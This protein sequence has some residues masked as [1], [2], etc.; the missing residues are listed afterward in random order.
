MKPKLWQKN[1]CMNN[2]NKTTTIDKME[3]RESKGQD[4]REVKAKDFPRQA[5]GLLRVGE[6]NN[7][8][9]LAVFNI[10]KNPLFYLLAHIGM[11]NFKLTGVLLCVLAP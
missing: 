7:E 8:R 6:D 2:N 4:L 10:L 3:C 5:A 11:C 9:V 1:M